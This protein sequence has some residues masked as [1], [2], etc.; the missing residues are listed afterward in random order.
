[1][2]IDNLGWQKALGEGWRWVANLGS[3]AEHDALLLAHY[4]G[5]YGADAVN[6][7][8]PFNECLMRPS[9]PGTVPGLGLYVRDAEYLVAEIEED[10]INFECGHG[11]STAR[12]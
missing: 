10:L 9:D 5:E 1:M 6:V 12:T 8:L 7:G 2:V 4:H 11:R 3:D